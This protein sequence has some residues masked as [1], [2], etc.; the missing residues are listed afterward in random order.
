MKKVFSFCL[1]KECVESGKIFF[2]PQSCEKRNVECV[3]NSE[4]LF[5]QWS[6]IF[7]MISSTTAFV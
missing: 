7:L 3:K 5:I 1:L 2:F 6:L 4:E